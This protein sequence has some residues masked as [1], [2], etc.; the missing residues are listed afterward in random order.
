[1]YPRLVRFLQQEV[2][3]PVELRAAQE[4]L[5]EVLNHAA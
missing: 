1:M 5:G 3:E 4:R 2:D